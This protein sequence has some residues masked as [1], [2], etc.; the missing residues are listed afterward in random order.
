MSLRP[1][2]SRADLFWLAALPAYQLL[3]TLRHEGSHALGRPCR[4]GAACQVGVAHEAARARPQRLTR[5]TPPMTSTPPRSERGPGT[6][7][8]QAQAM[9]AAAGGTR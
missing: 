7:P 5:T 9:R 2:K 4:A 1:P 3:G 8:N 6:S